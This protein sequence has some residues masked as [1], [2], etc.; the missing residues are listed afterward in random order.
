MEA[1]DL[2]IKGCIALGGA[3]V[4]QAGLDYLKT[5]KNLEGLEDGEKRR[6]LEATLR[7]IEKFFKSRWYRELTE[8]DGTFLKEQLDKYYEK[9]KS[10]NKLRE[11]DTLNLMRP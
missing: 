1:K 8:V 7:D 5:R 9:L 11:I 3:I 6:R 10:E 2:D 4:A